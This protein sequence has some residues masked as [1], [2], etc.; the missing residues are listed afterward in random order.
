MPTLDLDF[1]GVGTRIVVPAPFDEQHFRYYFGHFVTELTAA[2]AIELHFATRPEVSFVKALMDSETVKVTMVREGEG[3][4]RI[5]DLFTARSTQASPLPPFQ[6]AP[7]RA[8]YATIHAASLVHPRTGGAVLLRGPSFSGKSVLTLELLRRGWG[9]LSDDMSIIERESCTLRAFPRPIGIRENTRKLLPWLDE[10]V[11]GLE[12]GRR[13]RTPS[14]ETI[15]IQVEELFPG[16]V[17]DGAP[18]HHVV[19][20]DRHEDAALSWTALHPEQLG[21]ALAEILGPRS[22]ASV[23]IRGHRITYDLDRHATEI[24]TELELVLEKSSC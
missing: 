22:P 16:A 1:F 5:H 7:F 11:A 21:S 23:E 6:L 3:P 2:P 13:I 10:L 8:R 18:L 17:S 9:F 14:G 12:G 4:W 15:M 20:L 19:E 24:A